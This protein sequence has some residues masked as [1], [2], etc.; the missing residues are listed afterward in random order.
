M[1]MINIP[2]EDAGV[3]LDTF[4]VEYFEDYSRSYIKKL[5]SESHVLVNDTKVKAGYI[6][7]VQDMITYNIPEDV[8][9]DIYPINMDLD[10]V[11]E[12][13]DIAVINKPKGL[14][15]HPS[16]TYH[17]PTLVHGL[18]HQLKHLMLM[19]L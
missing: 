12:D 4:L 2:I 11:Y 16:S 5:I 8:V 10:I 7:K 14:V 18:M 13:D 6:L 17:G 1:K 9:L 3:R 15:V 19:A